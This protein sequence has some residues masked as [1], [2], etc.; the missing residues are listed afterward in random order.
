MS[1][2]EVTVTSG[3]APGER[4][5]IAGVNSLSEGQSVKVDGVWGQ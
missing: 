3:L 4:V 2:P 5:V 1:G